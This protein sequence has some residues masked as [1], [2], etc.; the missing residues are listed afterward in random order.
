MTIWKGFGRKWSWP[1]FKALSWS[2]PGST[3]EDHGKRHSGLP[4]SGPRSEPVVLTTQPRRS[5]RS[6]VVL[7]SRQ[8]LKANAKVPLPCHFH[9]LRPAHSLLTIPNRSTSS[10][11]HDVIRTCNAQIPAGNLPWQLVVYG[12]LVSPGECFIRTN[13]KIDSSLPS[14]IHYH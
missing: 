10:N 5:V 1:N 7:H 8:S 13:I 11:E 3:E 9:P 2:S 4:V 12:L 14:P 6:V